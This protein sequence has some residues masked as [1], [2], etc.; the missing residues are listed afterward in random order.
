M[1]KRNRESEKPKGFDG[2]EKERYGTYGVK[3]I[4]ER[5]VK[6]RS[7]FLFRGEKRERAK[8]EKK[9]NTKGKLKLF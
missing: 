5:A 9:M 3:R 7:T 4:E 6:D 8:G 1:I 2:R